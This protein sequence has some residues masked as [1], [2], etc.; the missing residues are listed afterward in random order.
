VTATLIH[1][2]GAGW[3]TND[4][5]NLAISTDPAVAEPASASSTRIVA[6]P[7]GVGRRIALTP[8]APVDLR[9][10]EELRFWVRSNRPARGTTTE[11]FFLAFAYHDVTD[12][13]NDEHRWMV[14]IARANR[15][16]PVAVGIEADKR[17]AVD[18]L[19]FE[20]IQGVGYEC[21]LDE[22]RAVR[23][24]MLRDAREAIE[25]R[26]APVLPLPAL[27]NRPLAAPTTVNAQSIVVALERSFGVGNLVEL[28]D[29]AGFE[30]HTAIDV[31]HD[32]ATNRTTLQLAATDR[33]TRVFSVATG[34][35]TLLVP[36]VD[37]NAPS[38]VAATSPALQ[39]ALVDVREDLE[40]T[41]WVS[42]RDSFRSRPTATGGVLTV[43]S[44][45]RS[46]RAY[47]AD[48]ILT[49]IAPN[50]EQALT[51]REAVLRRI[52][53]DEPL[54][55]HGIPAPVWVMPPPALEHDDPSLPARIHV[56]VG[57][58]LQVEPRAEQ[59]WVQRAEAVGGQLGSPDDREGIVLQ[60]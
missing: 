27:A 7:A 13:P 5:V 40:R 10:Y 30:V 33:V 53:I 19:R 28:R 41:P 54:R 36:I 21:R 12:T 58:Q 35:V 52:S 49:I 59:P 43:C 22:L 8:A 46:P 26:L 39:V 38:P 60:L 51:L 16:E 45:R 42:V 1:D 55:I 15:W 56:R 48:Y 32:T 9:G 25:Q 47:V 29:P 2:M 31:T 17:G 20:S 4:A 44:V 14:P 57:L 37:D 34:R 11:P 18:Q 6:T 3:V 50:R 24:E 23:P